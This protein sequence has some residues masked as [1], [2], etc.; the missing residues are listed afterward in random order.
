MAL[1]K[2]DLPTNPSAYIPRACD[3][4]ASGNLVVSVRNDTGVQIGGVQI[5]V[6]YTDSSGRSAQKRL[7]IRGQLPPGQVAS[8]NT[9]MGPYTPGSHCPAEVVAAE[10]AE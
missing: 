6:T 4:D 10:I 9:G 7:S 3:A 1:A 2:L 5:A 8:V